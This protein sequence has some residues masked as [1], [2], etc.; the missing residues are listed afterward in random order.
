MDER[1]VQASAGGLL[2]LM[3]RFEG[4]ARLDRLAETMRKTARPLAEGPMGPVL[5]GEWLGHALHPLL[6][7]FPMGCWLSAGMLDLVGGKGARGA[8]QKLVGMGV[9]WSL[10][11]MAA[12]ASEWPTLRDPRVRRVAAVHAAGNTGVT[13]CY[14]WSWKARRKGHH[15]RGVAFGI[16]GG[17]GAWA[18]GYMGGHL[19]LTRR[20]GTGVRDGRVP[21]VT[22][23]ADVDLST[24][25]PPPVRLLQV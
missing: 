1:A 22:A 5:R 11:T 15:L 19:S 20:A 9:A 25:A 16:A 4:D 23:D 8:A 17:L 2:A 21:S 6:T 18:T 10:P 14:Y 7:D 12:G 24:P 13:L 3:G